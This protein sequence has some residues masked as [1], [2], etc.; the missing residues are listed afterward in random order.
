MALFLSPQISGSVLPANV[1][2]RVVSDITNNR[3]RP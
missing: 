1:H 3:L 2:G